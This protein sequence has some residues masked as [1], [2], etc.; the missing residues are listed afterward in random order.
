MIMTILSIARKNLKRRPF[1]STALMLAA[2]LV[3]GL[4]FAGAISMKGVMMSIR[5]G[6]ERLGADLMVVPQG[7]EDKARSSII[8]GKPSVFYMPD[9]VL[10]KVRKVKGVRQ[11]S[12]QLFIKSTTYPCCT[13][14]DV[15]LVGFDPE[16]DFTVTP[17]LTEKLRRPL[18][19]D[20]A[21]VGRSIPVEK[22]EKVKFYGKD[23]TVVG[24]LSDTGIEYIDHAVYMTLDAAR[25][26]IRQS[27]TKAAVPLNIDE[28]ALST[29]LVQLDP[30]VSPERAAVFV[31]YEVQG[32]KAIA[33][34]D[35]IGSVKKQLSVLLKTIFGV[36]I[37][38]WAVTL[39]L[40]GV[41]FSM[42]VNERR[43][44]IGLLRAIGAKDKALFSLILIE[45]VIISL[46]GSILGVAAGGAGL[47]WFK[48]TIR[49]AFN[50]P[51][52]WPEAPF[53]IAAASAVIAATGISDM[54]AVF[55]PAFMTIK[56]EPYEAIRGGE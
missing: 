27:K 29:I 26:L 44:E 50:L 4:L 37:S 56:M 25:E 13:E 19:K 42:I 12:P 31:E 9:A 16:T 49:T 36:G 11:A 53:I 24:Y 55:Y 20:E 28:R 17:W 48:E 47:A 39:V 33:A 35:V 23:L 34:Q 41:V 6:A 43:R 18:G 52:L 14:V 8:A 7:Y 10:E 46:A 51:Y 5:L 15:L 38:L 21:V 45:S 1:R 30:A 32:V 22:G 3:S 40:I 2:A 54:A